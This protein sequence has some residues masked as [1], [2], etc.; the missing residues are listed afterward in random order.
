MQAFWIGSRQ[1]VESVRNQL[2]LPRDLWV[3]AYVVTP[4]LVGLLE[5]CTLRSPSVRVLLDPL[6]L[7]TTRQRADLTA[8]AT[9]VR[10]PSGFRVLTSRRLHAKTFFWSAPVP[11]QCTLVVGSSNLTRGGTG[12]TNEE[13]N[14]VLHG[15]AT[16]PTLESHRAWLEWLWQESTEIL[17]YCRANPIR[18]LAELPAPDVNVEEVLELLESPGQYPRPAGVPIPITPDMGL[19]A[20]RKPVGGAGDIGPSVGAGPPGVAGTAPDPWQSRPSELPPYRP[21]TLP[22]AV[23]I[24][25]PERKGQ[26]RGLWPF[27][28]MALQAAI[29]ALTQGQ[30]PCIALPT[31]AGKTEVAAQLVLRYLLSDAFQVRARQKRVLFIAPRRELAD[32][33]FDVFARRLE[34]A[35]ANLCLYLDG[36]V[37][38]RNEEPNPNWPVVVSTTDQSAGRSNSRLP[39]MLDEAG[40]GSEL[41][42][43]I[44]FDEAHHLPSNMYQ[45]TLTN[46]GGRRCQAVVGLTA[47]PFRLDRQ[48]LKFDQ[49]I[50]ARFPV[51]V[52]AGY[53]AKPRCA[54]V[55]TR[56]HYRVGKE[57][58][59]R[60]TRD[61][62]I[63]LSPR[64]L[65]KIGRMP[66]RARRIT[67]VVLELKR[68]RGWRSTLVFCASTDE[69]EK[70]YGQLA[71]ALG[72]SKVARVHSDLSLE[73]EDDLGRDEAVERFKNGR[74]EVLVNCQMFIEG[75]DAPNTD[76]VVIARPTTS[77]NYY[78]QMMGRGARLCEETGKREFDL[79][80]FRDDVEVDT[81]LTF[82]SCYEPVGRFEEGYEYAEE[83]TSIEIWGGDRLFCDG[84]TKATFDLGVP[85]KSLMEQLPVAPDPHSPLARILAGAGR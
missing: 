12:A 32:Q 68:Q 67:G 3:T 74:V 16:E 64:F 56:V 6:A 25:P 85:F 13:A 69:A 41:F 77:I 5:E 20:G 27:Q 59:S 15:L 26:F 7:A 24:V 23:T 14:V 33:F 55:E 80:E 31:G 38:T 2:A 51:L 40:V 61:G 1:Y 58:L 47:T 36:T 49:F 18:D 48:Q 9:R 50:L 71:E 4:G 22:R 84:Q 70:V 37:F 82:R 29:S 62:G 17:D 78:K 46:W 11:G 34:N 76:S 79:V 52:A 83:R 10:A 8:L 72:D 66:E 63:D 53:L 65:A 60:S 21:A 42:D 44:V 28:Q 35:R 39:R 75:F 30:R 19:G 54:V 73:D 43:A 45:D 57:D 81:D